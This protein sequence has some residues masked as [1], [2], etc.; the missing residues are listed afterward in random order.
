MELTSHHLEWALTIPQVILLAEQD[1]VL[2]K[3][4]ENKLKC[5]ITTLV[6][7]VQALADTMVTAWA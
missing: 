7:L 5:R 2:V 1:Q 6:K 4:S 3:R